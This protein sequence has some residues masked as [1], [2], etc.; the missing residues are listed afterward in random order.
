MIVR[1]PVDV[2]VALVET[3][4][5]S[6]EMVLAICTTQFL[7]APEEFVPAVAVTVPLPC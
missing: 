2:C 5:V 1:E 4:Y 3:V 6:P 7:V